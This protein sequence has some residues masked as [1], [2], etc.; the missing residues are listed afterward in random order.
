MVELDEWVSK[1][2]V[3]F[4]DKDF[5]TIR[6]ADPGAAILRIEVG[7]RRSGLPFLTVVV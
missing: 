5:K 3:G 1:S 2:T 6:S 4:V 7:E